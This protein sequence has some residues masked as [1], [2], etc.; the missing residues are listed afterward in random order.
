MWLKVLMISQ[1]NSFGTVV[2]VYIACTQLIGQKGPF[3]NASTLKT[4]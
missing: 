2:L 4:E 1:T 3:T